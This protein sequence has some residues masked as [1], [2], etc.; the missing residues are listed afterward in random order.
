MF[1]G[2]RMKKKIRVARHEIRVNV[3]DIITEAI[4]DG[5]RVGYS[6]AHK[7]TDAPSADSI[8]EEQSR[9]IMNELCERIEFGPFDNGR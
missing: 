9:A 7:H 2:G 1:N 4:E 8:L 5:L 6:R 3:Y